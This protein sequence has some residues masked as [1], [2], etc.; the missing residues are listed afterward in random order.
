ML[1][2]SGYDKPYNL[3]TLERFDLVSCTLYLITTRAN[4]NPRAGREKFISATLQRNCRISNSPSNPSRP[5]GKPCSR[6][7]CLLTLR[8]GCS[9][10]LTSAAVAR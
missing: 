9:G 10:T 3:S 4:G 5:R 6:A 2:A 8:S 1:V 7:R